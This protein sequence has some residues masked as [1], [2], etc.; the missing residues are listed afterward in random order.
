MNLELANTL[1][2]WQWLILGL[3]PPAIVALYFLKLRRLPV[4]VPSTYLWHRSIEDLHVNTLWQRLRKNQLLFL[5]L[6][7][8]GLGMLAVLQPGWRTHASPGK[9]VIFLIDRSA[10]MQASD[11]GSSRLDEAKRQAL[12]E[13]D[14]M[15]SGEVGMVIAFSDTAEVRQSFTDSRADLR[16]AIQGIGPSGRATSMV[17]ALRVASGLANPSTSGDVDVSQPA[18]LYVFSDGGFDPVSGFAL[19]NLEPVYR[20][21]GQAEVENVGI[22]A[23]NIRRHETR[24]DE[25]Q[26]FVRLQNFGTRQAQGSLTLELDGQTANYGRF[27]I[28]PRQSHAVV[29]NLGAVTSGVLRAHAAAKDDVFPLDDQAWLAINRPRRAR[30]LL[31]S[32]GNPDLQRSLSTAAV[33]EIAEL[34]LAETGALENEE[35]AQKMGAGQYD[36]VIFDRCQPK[37]MPLA[38]TMFIGRAPPVA[39]WSQKERQS[40]P[41]ILD[42]DVS[43]PL[44][45]WLDL[46]DV[47]VVEAA[48]IQPPPGGRVLVDSSR[49]PLLAIAPRE[50]FE[51]LALAFVLSDQDPEKGR[52]YAT[53][54]VVRRSF[55]LFVFNLVT[56]MGGRRLFGSGESYLAGQTVTL[57]SSEPGKA[58][59]VE[60]PSGRRIPLSES[61][62]GRFTFQN[63]DE[64]GVYSVLAGEE[65]VHRFAVNLFNAAESDVRVK[66]GIEI[67]QT[68]VAGQAAPRTTRRGIWKLLLSGG[69]AILLLEWYIYT[70]RVAM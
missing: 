20:P 13:V 21:I 32:A 36:L 37:Q 26:A 67:G 60:T 17:E 25:L 10:S 42:L 49:G 16:R 68:G 33:Q 59:S 38:N 62:R 31:I 53:N 3:V 15:T 52:V 18:A 65:V 35:F 12:A 48:P 34:T 61:T 54:W 69:L 55:P 27:A 7:V 22:V 44:M 50:G 39:G 40:L 41:Q 30:V 11:V 2:W 66:P 5:Q 63:T 47:D 45:E 46:G 9:H 23:M 6:A 8:V 51:D 56:Y 28:Q 24:P 4:E 64:L 19:G 43:H 57:D 29:F 14:Q 58:L 1:T 70:R